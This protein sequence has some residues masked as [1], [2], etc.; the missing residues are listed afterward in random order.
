LW[1][2]SLAYPNSLG[3]KGYVVVVVVVDHH[4]LFQYFF[5]LVFYSTLE[6]S[7]HH[8]YLIAVAVCR[9]AREDTHYLLY[10]YDLMRL[11]LVKESS[12]DS[13][14]LLEVN[15]FINAFSFLPY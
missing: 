6:N 12:D 1:V 13:D 10:I 14:M 9:Y 15:F 11:R 8:L 5:L 7:F 2:S 3:I 4:V